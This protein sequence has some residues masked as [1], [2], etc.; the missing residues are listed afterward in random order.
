MESFDAVGNVFVA[1]QQNHMIRKLTPN[2]D[3]S[4]LASV[5]FGFADGPAAVARFNNPIGVAVD[6]VGNVFVADSENHRIRKISPDG[7]VTTLAGSG[8]PGLVNGSGTMAQFNF[9][10]GVAVDETGNVFVADSANHTIRKISPD[11][12]VT[13]LALFCDSTIYGY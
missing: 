8:L 12:E 1:D 3:V 7:E 11:R 4:I 10:F 6:K 13:T 9:P 5:G 2:G